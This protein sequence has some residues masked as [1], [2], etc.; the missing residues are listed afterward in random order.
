M[1]IVVPIAVV[2]DCCGRGLPWSKWVVD[3]RGRRCRGQNRSQVVFA[4]DVVKLTL[5]VETSVGFS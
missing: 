2:A 5:A 1:L 3:C 4:V